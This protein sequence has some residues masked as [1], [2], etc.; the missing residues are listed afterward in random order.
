[1]LAKKQK[2]CYIGEGEARF[3]STNP[4]TVDLSLMSNITIQAETQLELQR[5]ISS[6]EGSGIPFTVKKLSDTAFP[7][8]GQINPYAIIS[9]PEEYEKDLANILNGGDGAS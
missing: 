4:F 2:P 7:S 9:V 3:F 6:L 1:M 5:I 8:L